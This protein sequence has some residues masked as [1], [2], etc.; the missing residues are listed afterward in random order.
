MIHIDLRIPP[1]SGIIGPMWIILTTHDDEVR[2]RKIMRIK[3][4]Y[5][6]YRYL[7]IR[8]VAR[9]PEIV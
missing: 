5:L 2:R 9:S 7:T 1:E 4:R 3:I 6:H 8:P